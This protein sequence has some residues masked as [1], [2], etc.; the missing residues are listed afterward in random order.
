MA[1]FVGFLLQLPQDFFSNAST[2]AGV[3]NSEQMQLADAAFE[4]AAPTGMLRP[5]QYGS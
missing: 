4:E 2:L 1:S 3:E 5:R